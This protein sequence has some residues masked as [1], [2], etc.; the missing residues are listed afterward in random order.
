VLDADRSWWGD[1]M[2][3]W[4]MF[5]FAHAE[6]QAGHT[7]FRKA[8][9]QPTDTGGARFRTIVY[10][11]MHAGTALAWSVRNQDEGTVQKAY[12]T[13]REVLDLL[14]TLFLRDNLSGQIVTRC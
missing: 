8:Y 11:G 4:T 14:P 6:K 12:G 13:R 2:A 3:D 5:I 1:P 10:D 7:Y 9:G